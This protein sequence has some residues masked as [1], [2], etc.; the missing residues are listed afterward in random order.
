MF[1]CDHAKTTGLLED[2]L[3]ISSTNTELIY[4]VPFGIPLAQILSLLPT[5]DIHVL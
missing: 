5:R 2:R 1:P 4:V 3:T